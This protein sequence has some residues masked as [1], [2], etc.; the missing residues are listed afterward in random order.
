M[1]QDELADFCSFYAEG[2]GAPERHG[3]AVH[4]QANAGGQPRCDRGEGIREGALQGEDAVV[5]QQRHTDHELSGT[6]GQALS[7]GYAEGIGGEG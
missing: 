3:C 5:E 1:G 7:P 4:G 2:F 6:K